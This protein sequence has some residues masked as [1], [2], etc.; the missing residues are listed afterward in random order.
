MLLIDIRKQFTLVLCIM[1]IVQ[2]SC[3]INIIAGNYN[4]LYLLEKKLLYI[5]NILSCK[6]VPLQITCFLFALFYVSGDI[7][8][9]SGCSNN[10]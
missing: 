9:S 7:I 10:F 4:Y 3:D 1:Y 2:L 8:Q 6:C 5:K